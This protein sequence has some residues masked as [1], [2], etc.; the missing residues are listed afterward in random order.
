MEYPAI[1]P[2]I[3]Q[4][5]DGALQILCRTKRGCITEC[6]STN[7]GTRWSRMMATSLPNPNSAIDA[8]VLHDERALLVH[9]PTTQG[10]HQLA[11]AL[12][13]DGQDWQ[14]AALLEDEPGEFSY[15]AVIQTSDGLVHVTY[16]WKR[17]LIKHVV[18]D[19]TKLQARSSPG[20]PPK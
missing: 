16:S 17:Q 13:A 9:N 15:P 10:R 4:H 6:W 8:L 11:I 20:S 18:L 7:N 1:Q 12:S 19:P 5:K 3:L 14:T 2:T